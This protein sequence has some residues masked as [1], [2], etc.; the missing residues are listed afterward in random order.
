MPDGVVDERGFN[1]L[2]CLRENAGKGL[3]LS[4]FKELFREQFLKLLLDE[5]RAVEAIPAMLAQDP[6]L[7]ARMVEN[8]HR[9]IEVVG[10]RTSLA[11][12]RWQEVEELIK[13]AKQRGQPRATDRET[14]ENAAGRAAREHSSERSKQH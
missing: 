13:F 11:K 8:L 3:S 2:R 7:A 6:D 1:L 12:D 14:R 9:M 5:H 10:L 4:E